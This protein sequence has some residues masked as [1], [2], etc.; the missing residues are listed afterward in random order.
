MRALETGRYLLRATN[1]GISAVIDA[2][3]QIIAQAPQFKVVAL[4]AQAQ[5]HQGITPYVQFGNGLIIT[6]LFL[7]LLLGIWKRK[8]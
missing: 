5:P 6:F 4:R 8:S 7:G 2:K 3:G 1:T